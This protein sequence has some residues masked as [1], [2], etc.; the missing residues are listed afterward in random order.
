VGLPRL[1]L[2]EFYFPDRYSQFRSTNY[3]FLLGQAARLGVPARRLCC[4][5]PAD[6]DSRERY[7]IELGA[8]ETRSLA[9]AL[10]AFAPTHVVLSEKLSAP[11]ERALAGALRGAAMWNLADRPPGDLVAWPAERLPAWLGSEV[12]W[13]ARGRG[14]YLVDAV[15][16]SYECV[17][18]NRRKGT[19]DPP[20]HVTAGT[21]CIYARRLAGN[22][23][24]DGLA[25]PAGVR[26]FGCSFCVGP[27]ELRYVFDTD[28]VELA[29]R[30][31]RA[32][33]AAT[34][35]CL[36]RDTYVVGGARVF[37]QLDRF[38]AAILRHRFPP[39]RFFF[40]CRIDEF[41]R[42]S[43][44][45]E[46][47]LPRLARAGHSINIFNMGLENF[48]PAE[49]ARLHKGLSAAQI[50][51]ADGILRRLEREHEA[52]FRFSRWGGYGLV[53]F[54]PWTTTADLELNLAHLR[55]L[56]GIAPGGFA[57]TS[58][59]QILDES[60]IRFAA[61]RDG[62]VTDTFEGF[63]YYDSGCVFRHDQRELPWRFRHPEI[64]ALYEVACRIAPITRFPDDDPLLPGVRELAA[65]VTS[66]GGTPFDLFGLALEAVQERGKTVSA[67]EIVAAVRRRLAVGVAAGEGAEVR[68]AAVARAE[69]VLRVL[70]RGRGRRLGGLAPV[71]VWEKTDAAG[72][73][74][75][76]I[77]LAGR[78]GRLTLR[79]LARRPGTPA[80]LRTRR[81]LLRFDADAPA[82]TPEKERVARTIAAH[83]E[84]YGLRPGARRGG[85]RRGPVVPL[86]RNGIS[87]LVERPP[88]G[89]AAR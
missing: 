16:P 89:E 62:L 85:S 31:C 38:F 86:G 84:R 34:G 48:S 75:L 68:S 52:A 87:R 1:L 74:Q 30:Q 35:T 69:E 26:R 24:F 76:V 64:G 79:W 19:S 61:E 80:F 39:S 81:F 4:W 78:G 33:R 53:L 25:F 28:P 55:R 50:E 73:P 46:A 57:L 40:A 49:N 70:A 47:L 44:R 8:R 63:H 12:R 9:A 43:A 7:V 17:A 14:R 10:R 45:I 27:V 2:V 82:D 72:G 54:T 13:S 65:L 29:V 37:L 66:R 42:M 83:L 36:S 71:R 41:L 60:A 58:K 3:P 15:Q 32:A 21:D 20:V 6:R 22:R 56:C 18:V 88:E 51:E 59:L 67:A 77:E 11:L 23:F 5:A